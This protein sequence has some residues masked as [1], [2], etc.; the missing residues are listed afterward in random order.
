MKILVVEDDPLIL[1]SLREM[2]EAWGYACDEA[3]D[4]QLAWELLQLRENDSQNSQDF[5][6]AIDAP[7]AIAN[8]GACCT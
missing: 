6:I 1:T 4:G 3:A 8:P 2:V 7:Y 5:Q